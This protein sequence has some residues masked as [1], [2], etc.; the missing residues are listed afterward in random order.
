MATLTPTTEKLLDSL[1]FPTNLYSTR[2]EQFKEHQ[3]QTSKGHFLSQAL[4]ENV[5]LFSMGPSYPHE[6]SINIRFSQLSQTASSPSSFHLPN[7]LAPFI[8]ITSID[9]KS[10]SYLYTLNDN[11][12][13]I[14]TI[15]PIS[16]R[17]YQ[18]SRLQRT[19]IV[20]FVSLFTVQQTAPLPTATVPTPAVPTVK[21][22]AVNMA[23][24]IAPTVQVPTLLGG[25]AVQPPT[26]AATT[27][28]GIIGPNV[29]T[30]KADLQNGLPFKNV[31]NLAALQATEGNINATIPPIH[32]YRHLMQSNNSFTSTVLIPSNHYFVLLVLSGLLLIWWISL[33]YSKPKRVMQHDR[34]LI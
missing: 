25:N 7:L 22:P 24:T 6:S 2:K 28:G 8:N 20:D 21:A 23:T 10:L 32:D 17:S 31:D 12:S 1:S 30:H 34:L 16:L 29:D 15:P 14:L 33:A 19:K 18:V 26:M 13:P 5:Y 3:C 11:H 27:I 4:P 9:E